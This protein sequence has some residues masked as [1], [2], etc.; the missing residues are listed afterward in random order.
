MKKALL[1]ILCFSF[2]TIN[3]QIVKEELVGNWTYH[4]FESDKEVDSIGKKLMVRF[5]GKMSVNLTS[6]DNYQLSDN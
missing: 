1:I 5:F 6:D 2:F 4:R 3:A